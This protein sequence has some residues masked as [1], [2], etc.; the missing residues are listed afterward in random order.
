MKHQ[1]FAPLCE[2]IKVVSKM[3]QLQAASSGPVGLYLQVANTGDN[4]TAD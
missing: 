3:T 4:V 2:E 1:Y